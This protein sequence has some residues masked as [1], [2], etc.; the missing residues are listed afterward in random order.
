[1]CFS[2]L[3]PCTFNCTICT[4]HNSCLPTLPCFFFI[5]HR[6]SLYFLFPNLTRSPLSPS[7]R[8]S[9]D[10]TYTVGIRT[11]GTN[12]TMILNG[13][14]FTVPTAGP[15]YF[16]PRG[17]RSTWGCRLGRTWSATSNQG[18]I[19]IQGM[20]FGSSMTDDQFW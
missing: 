5:L 6:H 14:R 16:F 7:P 8:P 3:C 11:V 13:Q 15:N 9:L 10:F 20:L 19:A 1:M 12:F 2:F 17:D 4:S 18:A